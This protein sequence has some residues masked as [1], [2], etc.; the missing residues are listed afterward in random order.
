M[1]LGAVAAWPQAA[2]PSAGPRLMHLV[3]YYMQPDEQPGDRDK[4]VAGL[5][6]LVTIKQVGYSHIGFPQEYKADDPQKNWHVSLL[7]CFAERSEMDAYHKDPKHQKFVD[8]CGKL[9]SKT[10]KFDSLAV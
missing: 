7:M 1:G 6:Q 2:T 4:L 9:W 5:K 3:L 8:E 10:V